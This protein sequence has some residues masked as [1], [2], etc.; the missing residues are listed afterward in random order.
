MVG[1]GFLGLFNFK[2]QKKKSDVVV[3]NSKQG[4]VTSLEEKTSKY[5]SSEIL[6]QKVMIDKKDRIPTRESLSRRK[7][8]TT[9]VVTNDRNFK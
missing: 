8:S 7:T 9:S 6:T 5:R 3:N 2:K 1:N 4:T